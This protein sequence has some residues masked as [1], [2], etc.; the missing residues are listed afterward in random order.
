MEFGNEPGSVSPGKAQNLV[1]LLTGIRDHLSKSQSTRAIYLA[2]AKE[3]FE[4]LP[5]ATQQE[6]KIPDDQDYK[7]FID[8]NWPKIKTFISTGRKRKVRWGYVCKGYES[9]HTIH[10]LSDIVVSAEK[11]V[12]TTYSCDT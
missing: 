2:M 8:C 9:P 4:S 12:S 6:S 7:D 11:A 10:I 5:S 3:Y 1:R